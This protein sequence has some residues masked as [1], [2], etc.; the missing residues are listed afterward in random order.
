MG[1]AAWIYESDWFSILTCRTSASSSTRVDK[2]VLAL[3]D[4]DCLDLAAMMA[5]R[6][7]FSNGRNFVQSKGN[8]GLKCY[9]NTHRTAAEFT[10]QASPCFLHKIRLHFSY[11]LIMSM[12]MAFHVG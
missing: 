12:T 9:S 7:V 8:R 5:E 4:S 3:K 1:Y 11:N 2:V 6:S 10:V